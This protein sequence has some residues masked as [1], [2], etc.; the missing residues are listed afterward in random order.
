MQLSTKIHTR[1]LG[2]QNPRSIHTETSESNGADQQKLYVRD[3]F[4]LPAANT[5]HKSVRRTAAVRNEMRISLQ[6]VWHT[7]TFDRTDWS[8]IYILCHPSNAV[9]REQSLIYFSYT[10]KQDTPEVPAKKQSKNKQRKLFPNLSYKL[11]CS[12]NIRSD[13]CGSVLLICR[14][15]WGNGTS[16]AGRIAWEW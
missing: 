7:I 14:L 3:K 2:N 10:S 9:T 12:S 5:G 6:V 1:N 8:F 13:P 4:P 11:I 15:A 16:V